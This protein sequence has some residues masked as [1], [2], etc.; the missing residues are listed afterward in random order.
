MFEPEN[1]FPIMAGMG[2]INEAL[3]EHQMGFVSAGGRQTKLPSHGGWDVTVEPAAGDL[4]EQLPWRGKMYLTRG[5]NTRKG[6]T[7]GVGVL[8]AGNN[9]RACI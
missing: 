8:S 1:E 4:D 5:D 3:R 6:V 2:T 7:M 9:K